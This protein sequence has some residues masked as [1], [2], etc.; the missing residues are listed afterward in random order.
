MHA[1]E[2][3]PQIPWSEVVTMVQ[4]DWSISHKILYHTVLSKVS[5]FATQGK[6]TVALVYSPIF[7]LIVRS[8]N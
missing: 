7:G 3:S 2:L 1:R 5:A 8:W 4:L 6:T